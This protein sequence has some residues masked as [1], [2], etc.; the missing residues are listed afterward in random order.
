MR[1]GEACALRWRD[2][3]FDAGKIHI[4]QAKSRTEI[5]TPKSGKLRSI[6]MSTQ[7]ADELRKARMEMVSK[8]LSSGKRSE[9][10]FPGTTGAT[11]DPTA[12]RRRHFEPLCQK[13]GLGGHLVK[14]LRHTYAS[15]LLHHGKSLKFVQAQLGHHSIT[16]TADTYSH[17][18][19]E[20]KG[21]IDVLDDAAD[22]ATTP[23]QPSAI[24]RNQK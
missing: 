24:I 21:G 2:I 5:N 12:W 1:V 4:R 11:I 20:Q 13:L 19:P 3:D 9:Y 15:L 10:I 18:I 8:S 14:D 17:L 7:L 22:S 16:I 23:P 6:E